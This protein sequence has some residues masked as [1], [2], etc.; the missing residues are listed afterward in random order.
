MYVLSETQKKILKD[1]KTNSFEN[2]DFQDAFFV[3]K[4]PKVK[5]LQNYKIQNMQSNT[6]LVK[7]IYNLRYRNEKLLALR[8]EKS[9]N[10]KKFK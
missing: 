5:E 2:L 1:Q 9:S 4:I 8:P 3:I 10:Q 7:A 6:V